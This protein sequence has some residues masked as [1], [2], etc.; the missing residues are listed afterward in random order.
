ML[1]PSRKQPAGAREQSRAWGRR[2][3]NAGFQGRGQG[4]AQ[5]INRADRMG[6]RERPRV[7]TKSIGTGPGR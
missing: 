1:V 3:Q 2:A 5:L 7:G 6:L 4:P